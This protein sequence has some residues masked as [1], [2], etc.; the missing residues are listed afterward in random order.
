M[1]KTMDGWSMFSRQTDIVGSDLCTVLPSNHSGCDFSVA[2]SRKG[3]ARPFDL[4]YQHKQHAFFLVVFGELVTLSHVSQNGKVYAL[5][6]GE[7][8]YSRVN[9][10]NLIILNE[11]TTPGQP[12]SPFQ[13]VKAADPA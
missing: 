12:R 5:Q 4:M 1:V 2:F 7:L 11:I 10:A 8:K 3:Q 6:Y 13:K 9:N